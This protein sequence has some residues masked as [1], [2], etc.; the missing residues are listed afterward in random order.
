[1]HISLWGEEEESAEQGNKPKIQWGCFTT[2]ADNN[3]NAVELFT[4]DDVDH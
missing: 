2:L 1:M 4:L 3:F